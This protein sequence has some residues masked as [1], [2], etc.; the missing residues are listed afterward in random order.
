MGADDPKYRRLTRARPRARFSLISTGNS[1]LWLGPDH[2]L[3]IDST[4]FTEN[5]KRFYFRDIQG[6]I[7]RKTDRYK[8]WSLALGFLGVFLMVMGAVTTDGVGRIIV[9]SFAGFFCLC[10]VLN[11]ALG[12]TTICYLQTA[13]QLEPLPSIHRLRKARKVLNRLR[14]MIAGAQGE[15]RPEEIAAH[16][17]QPPAQP[18]EQPSVPPAAAPGSPAPA[19]IETA[20]EAN[21]PPRI[22]S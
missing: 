21:L 6:L 12:P 2:V 22:L 4:G 11:L 17:G 3:C 8:Y 19:A 7:I 9:F 1:S 18:P 10:T 16:F 5:Y 13:V 14:P 15:L 20:G